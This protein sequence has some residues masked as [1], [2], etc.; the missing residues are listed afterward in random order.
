MI[1]IQQ[2]TALSIKIDYIREELEDFRDDKESQLDKLSSDESCTSGHKADILELQL[3]ILEDSIISLGVLE[4][5]LI[6]L[7]ESINVLTDY[8]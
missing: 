7:K 3:G 5:S 4:D 1:T 2:V 6:S 8:V